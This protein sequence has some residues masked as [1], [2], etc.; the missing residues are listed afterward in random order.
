MHRAG[1]NQKVIVL[2]RRK[3]VD[4]FLRREWDCPRLGLF[5]IVQHGRRLKTFL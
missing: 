5:Q 2:I 4:V 3:T 1:W